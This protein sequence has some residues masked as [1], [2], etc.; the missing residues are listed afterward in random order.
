MEKHYRAGGI[1][2][3]MD[4]YERAAVELK[5]LVEKVDGPEYGKIVD[6]ETTDDDCRS[7]QTI[8]SHVVN[9]GYGYA[10][11]IRDWYSIPKTS[12]GRRPIGR[13]EFAGAIDAMLAYT[14]DTLH[15]KWECS[16]EEILNV[17]IVV[18]WGPLYNLEQLL[19]HA[20]VHVLRHRRQIEKFAASGKVTLHNA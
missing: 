13:Q 8:L 15:G 17:R 6:T 14:S 20:L 16:D 10:D 12:P 4:E 7:V 2:A 5:T 18:R 9:S 3:V 1:G 19:E 11:Y